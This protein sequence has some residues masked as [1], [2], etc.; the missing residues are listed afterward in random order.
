V[1]ILATIGHNKDLYNYIR[2]ILKSTKYVRTNASHNTIKWH[3]DTSRIIKK[4]N[5]KAFH[6]F[7]IPGIK[8][9]TLNKENIFI[10]KNEIINFVFRKKVTKK[11]QYKTINLSNPLP[12]INK[13]V[14]YFSLYDGKHEFKILSFNKNKIV[15][16]SLSAF[17]LIPGKGLNI[18]FSIYNEKLQNIMYLDFLSKCK[19]VDFNAIGISYIQSSKVIN[20]IRTRFPKQQIISKIENLEGVKNL[21][22]IIKATD[23]VMIDRGDLCAEI[24]YYNLFETINKIAKKAKEY[25]KPLIMATENLDTMVFNF[26][27][28]KSEIISLEYSKLIGTTFIML[29]EETATSSNWLNTIKWLEK[30]NKKKV[31]KLEF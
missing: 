4:I 7:D 29:S 25:D 5:K 21:E 28:T 23:I 31:D 14:K 18:P 10:K 26:H 20:K 8:P 27:P 9:R 24:G 13:L 30:F 2:K 6:L 17:N 11:N 15:G 12:K 1:K 16:K 19:N 3:E 22:E